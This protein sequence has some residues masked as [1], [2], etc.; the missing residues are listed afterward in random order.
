V[1]VAFAVLGIVSNEALMAL[2]ERGTV[3]QGN[4]VFANPLGLPDGTEVLVRVEPI[5]QRL[6][7]AVPDERGE[8]ASLPFFGMWAG[9][10]DLSHPS[11][12]VRRER[13]AW[14]PRATRPD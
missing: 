7:E 4:I 2:T 10:Q 8:F 9:R 13:E 1:R 11:D 12:W 6:E 5:A 14:Q 3:H